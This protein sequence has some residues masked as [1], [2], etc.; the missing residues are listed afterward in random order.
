MP[1]DFYG[2]EA[3][4]QRLLKRWRRSGPQGRFLA[5]VGPSGSGKSSA[6]RAGLVPALRRGRSKDRRAG[7]S[8]T[9]FRAGIR[10]RS[11]RPRCSGSPRSRRPDCSRSSSPALGGLLQA[12]DRVVPEDSELVLVVDQFEEVFT[13]TEDEAERS[14]LLESLRVAA[15]DP[16]SRVRIVADAPRRLLRPAA[17]LPGFGELLGPNTEVVTPL[18]PDELERAIVRPA[19]SVGHDR[20]AGA[21]RPGRLRRR[22]TARGPAARAVRAHRA[23]RPAAGGTPH[24]RGVPRDR[25][26]R[27]RP[28]RQRRAPVRDETARRPRRRSRALPEPRDARRGDAGHAPPRTALRAVPERRPT[29]P[30]SSRPSTPMDVTVSSRSIATRRPESRPSRSP[31]RRSSAPGTGSEDGSTRREMTS[32]SGTRSRRPPRTGRPR[33]GMRAS[34]SAAPASSASRPG[35]RPPRSRRR[36]VRPSTSGHASSVGTRSERPRRPGRN[37]SEPWS[38]GRSAASAGSSPPSQRPPWWRPSSRRSRSIS[39]AKPGTRRPRRATRRPP[40]SPSAS[41]PSRSSRRTS[42]S[43]SCSP[44][45]RSRSTTRPRPAA[46]CSPRSGAAPM[47]WGSCTGPACSKRPP[48]A[49]TGRRWR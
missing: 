38:D 19:S 44:A 48:S 11:W 34:C 49:P 46:T 33:A 3:F 32:A 35:P 25:R 4:V 15:A 36:W 28:R 17:H 27:R 5:V 40:S 16:T 14:L 41:A 22:R 31:T 8:P 23:V 6:I 20:G 1:H 37:M 45:R 24:A 9:S 2:R 29:R 13:L 43:R 18:A 30:R 7:S 10:W 26:R 47:R 21:R 42:T 12:V 39:V